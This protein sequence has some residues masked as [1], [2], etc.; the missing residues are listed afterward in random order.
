MLQE[1]GRGAR[2]LA[3]SSLLAPLL[4]SC[5]RGDRPL[6]LAGRGELP[7]AW[8]KQL[9]DP[10]RSQLLEDPA[11][12]V[13]GLSKAALVQLTDGWA[14]SLP[15]SRWQPLAAPALLARLT[16][17]AA[18]VS[19]L[20]QA[21]GAP[22]LAYP[23][24]FTPWVLVLRSRPDLAARSREG[25]SLLFDPS[26]RDK[27]VLPSSPRLVMQLAAGGP[28]A[29]T[30]DLDR[31]R[32]LRRQA[33]AHDDRDGLN[34]LL[35]GDAEAAVLPAQRLIPLLRR[36]PRL[37]ILLPASGAPLAWNLLL[38]P[39]GHPVAPPLEWLAAILEPPLL[40][41]LLTA[42]W[43][44]P[45]PRAALEPLLAKLPRPMAELLLPPPELLRRCWSLPPLDVRQRL[46]LQNLWD[47]AA[48]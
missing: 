39:A 33:L 5:Q 46:M 13:N 14:T 34:L 21:E 12:V 48:P 44:P 28:E 43:V 16:P 40:Q 17:E 45:L 1:A 23:W 15:P 3:A 8:L 10:W 26:L 31:L 41:S 35:A 32:E 11:A 38:R 25:W 20:F 42:G 36:D 27:L 47:A 2:T 18:L 30:V 4:A 37:R 22:A 29:V 7:A 19:R 24:A 6:L 9:H